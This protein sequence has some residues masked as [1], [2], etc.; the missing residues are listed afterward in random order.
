[1]RSKQQVT[2]IYVDSS[3]IIRKFSTI[4]SNFNN[5]GPQSFESENLEIIENSSG[6]AVIKNLIV[7]PIKTMN[8]LY[9]LLGSAVFINKIVPIKRKT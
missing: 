5:K 1:M 9:E 3:N 7:L 2:F 4:S 8:D 6:Q